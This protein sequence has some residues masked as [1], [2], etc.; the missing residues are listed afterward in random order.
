M[1]SWDENE[2]GKKSSVAVGKQKKE[3]KTSPKVL[4]SSTLEE[5]ETSHCL[6]ALCKDMR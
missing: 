2:A 5:I 3:G 6:M 4:T 1:Y